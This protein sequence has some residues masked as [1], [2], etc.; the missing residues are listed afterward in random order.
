MVESDM[1][2]AAVFLVVEK[3]GAALDGEAL[4]LASSPLAD[5][6]LLLTQSSSSMSRI[7]N[8]LW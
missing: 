1:A 6:V 3:I 7:N 4:K 8:E 2:E 5:E